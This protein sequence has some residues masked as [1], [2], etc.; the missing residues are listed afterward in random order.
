MALILIWV[1]AAV[2]YGE[3]VHFPMGKGIWGLSDIAGKVYKVIL[4][5]ANMLYVFVE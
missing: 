4:W 2:I 1:I 3:I 5:V